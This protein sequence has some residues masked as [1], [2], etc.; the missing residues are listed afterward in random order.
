MVGE[1]CQPEGV[2]EESNP[3]M[4]HGSSQVRKGG[5]QKRQRPDGKKELGVS[6]IARY[7]LAFLTRS[8]SKHF[9]GEHS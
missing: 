8:E 1:E 5:L 9:V 4:D 7:R 3:S 2:A 6:T